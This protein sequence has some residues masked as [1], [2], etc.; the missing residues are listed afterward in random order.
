MTG[1]PSYKTEHYYSEM[2]RS[3]LKLGIIKTCLRGESFK[4]FTSSSIFSK[5]QVD[6]GTRLLIEAM[7]L[8]NEGA[9]LDVGCGYGV[10][11]IAAAALNPRLNVV[12]TDV[13]LR[14]V[15]LARL[16]I[17]TN[18]VS[19]AEVRHGNL[20][21]PIKG[22]VFNCVLSNPPVSA[23]METV[24]AIIKNAP[25]ILSNGGTL[26]MVVRSKIGKKTLPKAFT[27]AFGNCC[28]LAIKSGYR[29]LM[30]QKH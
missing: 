1:K 16:N 8:P 5:K 24:L 22:L 6:A 13:N 4:F 27:G 10:V 20:Y 28:V 19:N 29:V 15:R 12:L 11:G 3:E 23:G 25:P 26:Q 18:K 14:A 17:K 21:D 30:A 2:P 9:V 7:R